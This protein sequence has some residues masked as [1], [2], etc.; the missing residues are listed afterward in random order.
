MVLYF[1]ANE[2][3]RAGILF[4]ILFLAFRVVL[5]LLEI[6]LIA[7]TSKTKT[8]VDD[9]LLKKS[10]K[11][12]TF[13]ALLISLSISLREIAFAE[14]TGTLIYRILGSLFVITIGYLGFVFINIVLI[15]A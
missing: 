9:L 8:D 13:L 14:N 7:L 4:F 3:L 5:Y 11:P 15:R 12:V 2:Y 1:I 10:S 6:I